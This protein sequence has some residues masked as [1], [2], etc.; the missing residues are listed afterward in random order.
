MH[1]R[2]LS[3]LTDFQNALLADDPAPADG[4]TW[5]CG[6]MVNYQLGLAR[7]TL[8]VCLPSAGRE[9]RGIVTLQSYALADGTPCLKA[10]LGWTGLEE[11]RG[12]SIYA[13]PDVDWRREARQAAAEWMAGP[14]ALAVAAGNGQSDTGEERAVLVG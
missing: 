3:F 7:L 10:M 1:N 12:L 4:G 8:A 11:S 6:R 13:K 14:P 9:E 5:E 2:L